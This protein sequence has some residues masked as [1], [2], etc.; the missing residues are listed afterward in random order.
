MQSE[1]LQKI[2]DDHRLWRSGKGGARANLAGANLV[3]ANLVGADLAGANLDGA[4]L[5][6]ADLAGANLASAEAQAG[7]G[8]REDQDAIGSDA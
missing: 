8:S 4:N 3:V 5:A 6:G 2:L 7:G 1:E